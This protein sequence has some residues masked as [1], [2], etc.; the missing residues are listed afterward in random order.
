MK[1]LQK[2]TRQKKW[3]SNWRELDLGMESF[4]VVQKRGIEFIEEVVHTYNGK[5]ILIVSHGALIGL[6][7]EAITPREVPIN[8]YRSFLR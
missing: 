7:L 1:E 4:D 2:K 6:T 3:G 8:L 5:R